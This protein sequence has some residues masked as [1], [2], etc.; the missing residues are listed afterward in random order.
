MEARVV[1]V[2]PWVFPVIDCHGRYV[3]DLKRGHFRRKKT[4][5]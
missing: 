4:G 2:E 1:Q 5:R 3:V